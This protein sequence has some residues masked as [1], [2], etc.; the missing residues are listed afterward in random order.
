LPR[1]FGAQVYR[2]PA[3]RARNPQTGQLTVIPAKNRLRIRIS[4]RLKREINN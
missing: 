4:S 1:I 2:A 3:R